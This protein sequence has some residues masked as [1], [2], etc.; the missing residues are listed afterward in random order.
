M[1]TVE[2]HR[3]PNNHFDPDLIEALATAYENLDRDQACRAILLCSE[4]KHFCAGA[5]FQDLRRK[6][7]GPQLVG[8]TGEMPLFEDELLVVRDLAIEP[9]NGKIVALS[10]REDDLI[11]SVYSLSDE[12]P[13]LSDHVGTP[14]LDRRQDQWN[15]LV[16]AEGYKG[17][18]MVF[19]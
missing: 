3:A 10:K 14:V 9:H 19:E 15:S 5:N 1:A 13:W 4:G 8:S 11:D 7:G 18:E 12:L 6:Q 16:L 17:G 2:I